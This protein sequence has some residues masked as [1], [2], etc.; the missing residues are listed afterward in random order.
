MTKEEAE[1]LVQEHL[2]KNLK[3]FSVISE[4]TMESESCF[5]VFYQSDKYLK[6]N[7]FEDIAVGQGPTIVSK[8]DSKLFETGS[9]RFVED[10]IESFEKYGDP[11]LEKDNSKIILS[12]VKNKNFDLKSMIAL[13]KKTTN[14]GILESK[15]ILTDL[16]D[17]GTIHFENNLT[18]DDFQE[19]SEFGFTVDYAWLD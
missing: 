8:I 9:G 3:G 11:Y 15:Q 7:K 13:L 16:I 1:K 4:S 17:G 18:E 10:S 14:K 6:S 19:L 12:L 5:A 2:T